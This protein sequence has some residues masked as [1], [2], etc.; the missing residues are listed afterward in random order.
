[1]KNGESGDI[2]DRVSTRLTTEGY[3]Y[4]ESEEPA[5]SVTATVTDSISGSVLT[6]E[7]VTNSGTISVTSQKDF[8]S[9]ALTG[10]QSAEARSVQVTVKDGVFT[11]GTYDVQVE[12]NATTAT[13]VSSDLIKD[14]NYTVP[15]TD[16]VV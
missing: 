4:V 11:V 12:G 3:Y 1:M 6:A 2:E 8:G 5:V 13:L 15:D 14:K 10:L 7:T 9:L 16:P